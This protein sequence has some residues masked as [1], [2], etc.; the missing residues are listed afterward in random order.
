MAPP[1][2]GPRT[3][4][5]LVSAIRGFS[6]VV[7]IPDNHDSGHIKRSINRRGINRNVGKASRIY[8]RALNLLAIAIKMAED[9]ELPQPLYSVSK[10]AT[11][12]HAAEGLET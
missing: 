4:D 2:T 9:I 3:P 5:V 1:T 12:I 11:C 6:F 7:Y 8:A 10:P